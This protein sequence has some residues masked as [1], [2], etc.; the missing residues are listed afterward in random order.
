[1]LMDKLHN[2]KKNIDRY[3]ESKKQ[4]FVSK[5]AIF[6]VVIQKLASKK[7]VF[8]GLGIVGG[9]ILA[10]AFFLVFR[11]LY[12][13]DLFVPGL[14]VGELSEALSRSLDSTPLNID[15]S[16]PVDFIWLPLVILLIVILIVVLFRLSGRQKNLVFKDPTSQKAI[17]LQ[18]RAISISEQQFKFERKA[19]ISTLAIG[20]VSLLATTVGVLLSLHTPEKQSSFDIEIAVANNDVSNLTE[21]SSIASQNLFKAGEFGPFDSEEFKLNE[22]AFENVE[23]ACEIIRELKKYNSNVAI[24]VGH[25]DKFTVR[26]RAQVKLG[27]NATIAQERANSV[28]EFLKESKCNSEDNNIF[29]ITLIGGPEIHGEEIQSPDQTEGDRRAVVYGI[30]LLKTETTLNKEPNLRAE[31]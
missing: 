2:F 15:I 23:K 19:T 26:G 14:T 28:R 4:K 3:N 9:A 25:H 31:L 30:G 21:S 11:H 16:K 5:E 12:N 17:E 27:S 18:E 8:S 29:Y 6:R 7:T 24:I 10:S 1:M 20:L 13:R 22:T